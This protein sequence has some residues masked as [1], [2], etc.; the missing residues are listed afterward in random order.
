MIHK[1]YDKLNEVRLW[2]QKA[3]QD[4]ISARILLKNDPPILETSCFH[5]QQSVEKCLKAFL[6]WK[7]I[8]FEKVHNLTYLLDICELHESE[9]K[10]FRD[11]ADDLESYAVVIR[12]PSENI[13]ISQKDAQEALATAEAIWSFILD[14][15]S[16]PDEW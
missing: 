9:F 3:K 5:C 2:L 15:I 11:R 13:K 1:I 12:Y 4:L 7:N 16:I 6:V 14:I 10:S 8:H